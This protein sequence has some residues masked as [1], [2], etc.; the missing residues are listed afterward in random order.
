MEWTA[1]QLIKQNESS[2][3]PEEMRCEERKLPAQNVLWASRGLSFHNW[4]MRTIT[5]PK[6]WGWREE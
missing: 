4:K 3:W 6:S 2:V 5:L 1:V